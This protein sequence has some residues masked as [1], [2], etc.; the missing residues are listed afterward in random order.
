MQ[1][2]YDIAELFLSDHRL[3]VMAQLL[4]AG[5]LAPLVFRLQQ[6]GGPVMLSQIGYIAA[7]TSLLFAAFVLAEHYSVMAW[8][9]VFVVAAGVLLAQSRAQT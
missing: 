4:L 6:L 8:L 5:C 2:Q 9:S 7:A 3:L 1:Q